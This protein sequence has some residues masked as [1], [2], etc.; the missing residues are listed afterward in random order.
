MVLKKLLNSLNLMNAGIILDFYL[1]KLYF[2]IFV[3]RRF[4]RHI[5][6]GYE[7]D[8]NP[9]KIVFIRNKISLLRSARCKPVSNTSSRA[10]G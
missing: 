1:R 2:Y 8:F 9:L 4:V 6:V 3:N 7:I 10:L 5:K